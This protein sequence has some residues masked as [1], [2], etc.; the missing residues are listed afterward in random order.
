MLH[1]YEYYD[2]PLWLLID[3]LIGIY[4]GNVFVKDLIKFFATLYDLAT[5]MFAGHLFHDLMASS[6]CSDLRYSTPMS[7]FVIKVPIKVFHMS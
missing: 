5:L 6:I 1:L 7:M 2:P 4:N 3:V